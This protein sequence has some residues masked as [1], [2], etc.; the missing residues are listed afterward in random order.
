VRA[1]TT[2]GRA[3]LDDAAVDTTLGSV[4]KYREDAE[5]VRAFGIDQLVEAARARAG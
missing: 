4:I 2:L 5:R 3:E 1:L